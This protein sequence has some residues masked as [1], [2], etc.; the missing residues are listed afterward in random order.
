MN[1]LFRLSRIPAALSENSANMIEYYGSKKLLTR[2]FSDMHPEL[3]KTIAFLNR[4]GLQKGDRVGII[5]ANSYEFL[6]LDLAVVLGGYICVPF[7]DKDFRPRIESLHR[8][9]GLKLLFTDDSFAGDESRPVYALPELLGLTAAEKPEA[10]ILPEL[11]DEDVFTVIFT[12][13]TTGFPKGIEMRVKCVEEWIDALENRFQFTREDKVIDFLPLS[14]SNARLF[15]YG[16][17]LLKFNLA[18]TTPDQMM[19][20]LALAKPT[21]LQGVPYLF[22]TVYGTIMRGINASWG[23]RAAFRSYLALRKALPRPWNAKLQ[24]KLFGKALQFWGGSMR[25]LV[26][27]SA[28]IRKKIL[29][30]FEAM[31]LPVYEAYGI[32]EIGLVSINSPGQYR[33]GSVG[34]PFDTKEIRITERG[35]ILVK[36]P[37]SWGTGYID[38]GR[39]F[40]TDTFREDGFVSTGDI[41]RVDKDGYLYIQGRMKEVL[42]LTNGEKIHPGIIEDQ[43]LDSPMVKQAVAI[44]DQL[45][46][47]VCVLVPAEGELGKPQADSLIRSINGKLSDGLGIK[48][49][50]I[51]REPFTIDNGLLNSTLKI[52]RSKVYQAYQSE[53]EALYQ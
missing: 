30:L 28:P 48:G 23:T 5:A 32:N 37:Y 43:L 7:P 27:G 53:I 47:I 15:V 49:Y 33:I 22:E 51:A 3:L 52:N 39:A 20:V 38:D 50:V 8:E 1:Q 14:I 18:L 40:G 36:S 34:R 41:G 44:G 26:T 17:I 16:A 19:R 2:P 31:G 12:S 9:Y 13:G 10:A 24:R 25:I 29:E 45:P 42:V 4:L 35:E 46:F 21:I 11:H 6:L